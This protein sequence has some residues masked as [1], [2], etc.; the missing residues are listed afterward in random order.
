MLHNSSEYAIICIEIHSLA[1]ELGIQR[2]ESQILS[3]RNGDLDKHQ[4]HL[5]V[6][7]WSQ[8]CRAIP[9]KDLKQVVSLR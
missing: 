5:D 4:S 8:A 7:E 3:G 2:G 9:K 6:V 1:L